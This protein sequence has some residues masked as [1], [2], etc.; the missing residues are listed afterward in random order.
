MD[1]LRPSQFI[2]LV[3][4]AASLSADMLFIAAM[5]CLIASSSSNN[6]DPEIG[7]FKKGGLPTRAF[8]TELVWPGACTIKQY[9]GPFLQTRSKI[10][11]FCKFTRD[12]DLGTTNKVIFG[13][14]KKIIIFRCRFFQIQLL[15]QAT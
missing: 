7:R 9:K 1:E 4:C 11:G 8:L 3:F 10:K 15:C 12:Y 13:A 6:T 14:L 2:L 5:I